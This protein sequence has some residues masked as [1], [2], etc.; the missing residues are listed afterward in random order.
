MIVE[1]I[2]L[3][4]SSSNVT[5]S[6]CSFADPQNFPDD[7]P[8]GHNFKY[9]FLAMLLSNFCAHLWIWLFYMFAGSSFIF[10][11]CAFPKM[12]KHFF[13]IFELSIITTPL[14]LFILLS[15]QHL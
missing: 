11:S 13:S 14:P 10:T 15:T 7:D 3:S 8:V 5:S 1:T 6:L 9:F 2:G 12:L 4:W